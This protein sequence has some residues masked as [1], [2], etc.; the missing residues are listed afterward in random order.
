MV[1][2]RRRSC[3][4]RS[5]SCVVASLVL[6]RGR[7]KKKEFF[8]AFGEVDRERNGDREGR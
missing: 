5:G 2:E 6:G 1:G 3:T 4:Q 8:S 7:K